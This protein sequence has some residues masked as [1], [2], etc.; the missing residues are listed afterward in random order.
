MH[1]IASLA[2]RA[3]IGSLSSGKIITFEIILLPITFAITALVSTALF[4]FVEKP[5]SL[6]V[7]RPTSN[8][9]AALQQTAP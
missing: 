7:R 3:A 1:I 6:A 4:W 5:F 8:L 2:A 9:E